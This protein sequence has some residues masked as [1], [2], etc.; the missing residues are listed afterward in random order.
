M[1][2]IVITCAARF[3]N[4]DSHPSCEFA[5][6]RRKI[7][8]LVIHYETEDAAARSA[9]EAMKGLPAWAHGERRSFLLVKR[10]KRF[11][12]CSCPLK[13]KIR[14]NHLHDV[15]GRGD[16]LNCLRRY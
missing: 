1:L 13:W 8:V 6:G 7:D 16:L 10:T 2:A 9:A 11:E 14:A 3:Y 4:G 15:V 5:N 12:T